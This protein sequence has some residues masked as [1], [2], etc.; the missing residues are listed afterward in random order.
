MLLGAAAPC[1]LPPGRIRNSRGTRLSGTKLIPRKEN[2]EA[3]VERLSSRV[4]KWKFSVAELFKI[5]AGLAKD[6]NEGESNGACRCIASPFILPGMT[7]SRAENTT[8]LDQYALSQRKIGKA[9]GR[10]LPRR[11]SPGNKKVPCANTTGLAAC[12]TLGPIG[13]SQPCVCFPYRFDRHG[14]CE[15]RRYVLR[16]IKER[17]H[18]VG[19]S[20]PNFAGCSCSCPRERRLAAPGG[21][22]AVRH[23]L[24]VLRGNVE[25]TLPRLGNP[26]SASV[27]SGRVE[28][29]QPAMSFTQRAARVLFP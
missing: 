26:A 5:R 19:N 20:S 21:R 7:R 29:F 8:W 22:R 6:C 18:I 16:S 12:P 27:Q 28:S 2:E 1:G 17:V 25:G 13:L 15:D 11:L 9:G 3:S 24:G 10:S 23:R 14:R 4:A